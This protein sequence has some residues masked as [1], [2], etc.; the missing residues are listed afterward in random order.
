MDVRNK[1]GAVINSDHY[2]MISNLRIKLKKV[3]D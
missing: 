1:R 2:I 3:T